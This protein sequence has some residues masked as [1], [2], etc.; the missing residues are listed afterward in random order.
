MMYDISQTIRAGMPVYPGN[1]P[2]SVVRVKEASRSSSALSRMSMGSHTGTH[3]DAPRHVKRSGPGIDR[4]A[5]THCYGSALVIDLTSIAFGQGITEGDLRG[6]RIR[7]GDIVLFKTK[8]SL[9]HT[10][11]KDFVYLTRKGAEFLVQRKVRT[12]GID[13]AGIQKFCSGECVAHCILLNNSVMIFEGLVLTHVP[14][15]RYIFVGLPIKI[16]GGDAAPARAI[17]IS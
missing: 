12:V 7:K 13:A 6:K 8:N 15:G 9:H 2:V 10:F 3:M 16:A 4:I 11:R 1:P 5:L 17:L 14:A